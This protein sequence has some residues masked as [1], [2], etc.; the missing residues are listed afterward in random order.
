MK[1]L[2]LNI[3]IMYLIITTINIILLSKGV[4][5]ILTFIFCLCMWLFSEQL[6]FPLTERKDKEE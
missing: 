1:I 2:W 3:V 4:P 6:G 5:Y